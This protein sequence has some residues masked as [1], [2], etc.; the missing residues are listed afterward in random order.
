IQVLEILGKKFTPE[1]NSKGYKVLPPYIR[2]IQ[3][4]GVDINTL[5]EIVEGMKQ[6]RW[7]IENISFGSGGA[8]LQKLTRDL[9]NCSF[10]CSYVVTNGL[11]VNVFK[12]PVADPNKRSKKGRLSLHRT[13]GGDFVTLEEGKGDL[14]EY[15]VDLLHTV[16][17]N[18]K[19]VKSYTFDEVRDNAKL[20]DS[21]IE[22]FH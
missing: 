22:T 2:V 3:G 11:G 21:D 16:F 17:Q 10:K 7:S 14:E 8:L 4:D 18:G 20:T 13:Q 9:L 5:Q 19:M 6:H 12:D 1:E 15:G